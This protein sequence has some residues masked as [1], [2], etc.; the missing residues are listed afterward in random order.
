MKKKLLAVAVA[1][2][3]AAPVA[4][5]AES[6]VTISGYFKVGVDNYK[7]SDTSAGSGHDGL[8][9]SVNRITDNS[10]RIIFG[11]SE[12][13]GGGLS[14]IA[15]LDVRPT[16]DDGEIG[17]T[18][19]NWVGLRSTSWGTVTFGRH[20]LHYGKQPDDTASRGALMAAAISLMDY[21]ADGNAIA[22]ATRTPNVIR[23]DSPKWGGFAF[24]AAYST[25]GTGNDSDLATSERKGNAWTVNPSFTGGNFQVG[26]SHWKSKNDGAGA[27]SDEKSDVVYGYYKIAG[28]KVGAAVNKSK[29]ENGTTGAKLADRTNWTIPVSYTV[30]PHM[31]AGHF[32]KAGEDDE[33][34]DDTGAKMW[35]VSY[36]YDFSKTTS[37][38]L[39]YASLKN[40]DNAAYNFFTNTGSLGSANSTLTAGEDG[41]LMAL[42]LKKSF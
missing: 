6:A 42:T 41:K 33:Q 39:T 24:T 30:G 22:N 31:I 18:G 20:D 23:Y 13:L 5:M 28:F 26:Y 11:I 27:N 16:M 2:V 37:V 7:V 4:A 10:S 14:G 40:D 8:N 1:G 19:N 15:Q 21:T 25:S 3:L 36:S 12:D 29:V 34:G 9:K 35:A 38:A 17:A 32:T